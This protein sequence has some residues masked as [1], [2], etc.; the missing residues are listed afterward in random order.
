MI[1]AVSSRI[2]VL[3]FD[4]WI[5]FPKCWRNLG[6]SILEANKNAAEFIVV[7]YPILILI[8]DPS[9]LI[10]HYKGMNMWSI[11]HEYYARM[12]VPLCERSSLVVENA[13][14]DD[15][16][17]RPPLPPISHCAALRQIANS[18]RQRDRVVKRIVVLRRA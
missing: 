18:P 10:Q 7:Q 5:S 14:K 8:D 9:N 2:V 1:P 13:A 6:V 15:E 17:Y 11:R 4:T 3:T 16:W 12:C